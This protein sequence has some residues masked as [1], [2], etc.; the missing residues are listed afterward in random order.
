MLAFAAW[1]ALPA[2]GLGRVD[3]GVALRASQAVIG[4]ALPEATLTDPSGRRLSLRELEGKPL[5][6]SFVFTNC[7]YLCSALTL[8]LRDVVRIARDALGNDSFAVL[9]VGFDTPRDTPERMAQFARERGIRD[10]HWEFLSGDAVTVRRLTDA[11][12][13]TWAASKLGFDHIAQVTLI[14]SD[15]RIVR[16]VYGQDFSPPDLVEPLKSLMLKGSVERSPVLGLARTA[17][18]WCTVYDPV[19]GRYR[20][21]YS[22]LIGLLP[23]IIV[24]LMVSI[25]ILIASRNA[26]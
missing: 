9:T 22:M 26:K 6:L 2:V 5:V 1:P 17:R 18:L 24:L 10:P 23:A 16:Q 4:H 21:D 12:G 15:G 3:N 19:T 11:A 14:N 13:F 7:T 20:V 8:H 25:A